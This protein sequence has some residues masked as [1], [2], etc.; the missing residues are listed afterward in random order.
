V[1]VDKSEN[2]RE[3]CKLIREDY[4][5]CL[6]HKKEFARRSAIKRRLRELGGKIP[7]LGE[8][9]KENNNSHDHH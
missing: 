1:C 4:F 9:K 6:H 5:E 3:E 2:P 7:E 8:E